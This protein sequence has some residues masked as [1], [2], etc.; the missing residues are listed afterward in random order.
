MR[1]PPPNRKRSG[2]LRR[3]RRTFF[4]PS[5]IELAK[6]LLGVIMVR[7]VGGVLRRARINEV[8][9][10]LGPK[11]LASHASKGRTARTEVMFG[12]SGRAYVYLIYGMH[13]MFNIVA[14]PQGAA[15]AVLI[16]GATALDDWAINLSGPGRLARGFGITRADNGLDLAGD[17]IFFL[18]DLA[19]RPRIV[20]SKRIGVD[21]AGHWK[22]RL[23]R[24]VDA[25]GRRQ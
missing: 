13:Q 15:E 19:H 6:S 8:E 22:D 10:Y 5:A 1:K 20:R 3:L 17:D 7:R 12:P 2:T 24:F 16:R 18:A 21:Y 14:G 11:D 23:L 9:A 25:S 4:Q